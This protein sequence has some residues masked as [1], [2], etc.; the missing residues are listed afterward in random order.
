MVK[1][2]VLLHRQYRPAV[3]CCQTCPDFEYCLQ[4]SN[5][6]YCNWDLTLQ[7]KTIIPATSNEAKSWQKKYY[8]QVSFS[9]AKKS[10]K[11]VKY[12][13]KIQIN[14]TGDLPLSSDSS[15]ASDTSKLEVR[16]S[17]KSIS[18]FCCYKTFFCQPYFFLQ[19]L[20][21]HSPGH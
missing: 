13:V 2:E 10:S 16:S 17:T 3:H 21:Y 11:I 19:F 18:F 12:S 7:L 8:W 20:T 9:K 14:N 4:R 5:I 1:V 6:I 15:D